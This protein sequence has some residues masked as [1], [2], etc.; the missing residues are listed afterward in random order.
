MTPAKVWWWSC[1]AYKKRLVLLARLLKAVNFMVYKCILPFEAEIES[2][3]ILEH[4]G[5]G[6]VIHPNV[7]IGKGV[8]IFHQV[9]LAA[10]T[11]IG[12]E[13]KIHLEDGVMLGAGVIVISRPDQSLTIGRNA[14]IG[15]GAVVTHSV[16]PDEIWAGV[17]A[18][19]L[20]VV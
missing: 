3:I 10:S 2:D 18:K 4:Y 16:P 11:W 20:R 1:Q 7:K 8:R 9:T 19:K 17:P 14:Q 12:S 5:L 15:A 6:V 13:H